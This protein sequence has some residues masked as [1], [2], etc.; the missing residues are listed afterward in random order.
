MYDA[1]T[2]TLFMEH[3]ERALSEWKEW[4]GFTFIY[5]DGSSWPWDAAFFK[6]GGRRVAWA[7]VVS[8]YTE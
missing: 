1:T 2:H 4:K 7:R 3:R 8:K 6:I 5:T